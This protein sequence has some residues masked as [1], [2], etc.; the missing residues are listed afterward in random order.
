MAMPDLK[1]RE[2]IFLAHLPKLLLAAAPEAY[3]PRLAAMTPGLVGADIANLCNEAAIQAARRRAARVS[4]CDFEAAADRVTIGLQ[5]DT[6][7]TPEDRLTVAYHEAGHAVAGWHCE[8]TAT[9]L[10]VS[11]IPRG[12]YGGFTQSLEADTTLRRRQHIEDEL[13]ALLAGRAAELLTFRPTRRRARRTT[14]GAPPSWPTRP[15]R[16]TGWTRPWARWPSPGRGPVAPP[17]RTAR[18]SGELT[19][20][21]PPSSS[22]SGLAPWCRRRTSG[23][24]SC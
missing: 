6:R 1:A 17:G 9:P 7:A 3:A 19:R 14:S 4:L 22:T 2:R 10:K 20:T 5:D 24:S 15:W 23:H 8:T 11:I 18:A 21:P 12:W 16:G 13:V